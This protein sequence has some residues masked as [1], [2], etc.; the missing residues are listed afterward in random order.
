MSF[1]TNDVKRGI[2]NVAAHLKDAVDHLAE[3]TSES[4]EKVSEKAKEMARKAGDEMIEQG[5]KLKKAA[6]GPSVET[7]S[8]NALPQE[9]TAD[10]RYAPQSD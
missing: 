4:R 6:A 2:D 3:R 8:E 7:T 1:D 9:K 10:P 5:Q